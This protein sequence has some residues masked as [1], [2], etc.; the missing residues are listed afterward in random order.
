MKKAVSTV[1]LIDIL[2]LLV[3]SASATIG[4][5]L[6]LIFRIVGIGAMTFFAY[7]LSGRMKRER[8]EEMGVA[9]PSFNPITIG[10]DGA[11]LMLPLVFPT[12]LIIFL[13]SLLTSFIF[14]L[15]GVVDTPVEKA[16]LIEMV[17]LNCLLPTVL[18]EAIFRY[19]PMILI[20]PY[21]KRWCVIISSLF[22]ALAHLSVFQIPYALVAGIVLI[23][24]N[25]VT[26]S[27]IPSLVIH[28]INNLYSVLFILYGAD[29]LFLVISFAILIVLVIISF[30]FIIP[31]LARYKDELS[32]MFS[33]GVSLPSV[34]PVLIFTLFSL[35]I[36]AYDLIF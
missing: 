18:E 12:V 26:N 10:R 28:F 29:Q 27:V 5:P 17:L 6:G 1:T 8:E 15:F 4:G 16:P 9:E 23:S 20:A 3:L 30:V 7:I 2:F 34:F 11:G 21:S 14:G 24:V 35:L 19:V 13:V 22:F 31:R 32:R 36:M 25:L 33:D